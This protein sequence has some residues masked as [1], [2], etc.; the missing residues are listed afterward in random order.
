[1]DDEYLCISW[2]KTGNIHEMDMVLSESHNRLIVVGGKAGSLYVIPGNR[3]ASR[4]L[5]ESHIERKHFPSR[6]SI[7]WPVIGTFMFGERRNGLQKTFVS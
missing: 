7:Y 5:E 3:R 6:K 2:R 4:G 1:M